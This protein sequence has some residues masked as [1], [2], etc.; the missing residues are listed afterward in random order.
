MVLFRR[1]SRAYLLCVVCVVCLFVPHRREQLGSRGVLEASVEL[2]IKMRSWSTST[3]GKAGGSAPSSDAS[4]S[5]SGSGNVA[6]A[7]PSRGL[8]TAFGVKRDV[9]K[10][11]G[12]VVFRCRANQDKLRLNG[13][14]SQLLSQVHL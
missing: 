7:S 1:P 14:I 2:L 13:G 8:R 9:V 6:A 11:V 5:G 3:A 4:A 12:N 10:L